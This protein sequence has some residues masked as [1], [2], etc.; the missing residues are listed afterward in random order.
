M[1]IMDA[2]KIIPNAEYASQ[3]TNLMDICIAEQALD[4]HFPIEYT[5][6]LMCTGALRCPFLNICGLDD[7]PANNVIEQ[8]KKQRLMSGIPKNYFVLERPTV[9]GIVLLQSAEGDVVEFDNGKITKKLAPS[10][11]EYI[12]QLFYCFSRQKSA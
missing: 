9:D 8:T 10:L 3:N 1:N 4:I 7:N 2:I 6:M 5:T 12:L 11:K